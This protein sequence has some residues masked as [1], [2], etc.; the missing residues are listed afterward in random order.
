MNEEQRST[1]FLEYVC[2][3]C[4][5]GYKFQKFNE[6]QCDIVYNDS[7]DIRYGNIHIDRYIFNLY[8]LLISRA[9]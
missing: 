7:S 5:Q 3:S 9:L 1:C 8:F 6:Q 4:L 2:S